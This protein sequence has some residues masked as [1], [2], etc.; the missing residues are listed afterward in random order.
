[1]AVGF[2]SSYLFPRDITNEDGL[3]TLKT[4][5][6]KRETQ[7]LGRDSVYPRSGLVFIDGSEVREGLETNLWSSRYGLSV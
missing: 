3:E 2:E 7:A 1:M 4:E 6:E 5:F